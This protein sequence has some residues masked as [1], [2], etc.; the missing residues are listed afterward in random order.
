MSRQFTWWRR[1][2][3][4]DHLSPAQMFK[5]A[6][7]L[8]QRI[9]YGEYEMCPLWQQSYL[10]QE[11]LETQTNE[12][13]DRMQGRFNPDTIKEAKA[14]LE[15]KHFKR[16]WQIKSHHI[17]QEQELLSQLLNDLVKE[18]ETLNLDQVLY[19]METGDLT[20]RQL[21][22]TLQDLDQGRPLRTPEQID[23]I[24][25]LFNEQPRHLLKPKE[26]RW[27]PQFSKAIRNY[28]I[29]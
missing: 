14:D 1:F 3:S 10:E 6:S 4:T 11:I 19:W 25:R 9:E 24:P 16:D 15:K 22:F 18:F 8:L 5:G 26:M 27:A 20:T 21:Y 13:V 23:K 17:K 7:A 2:H 12:L 29:W 28:K